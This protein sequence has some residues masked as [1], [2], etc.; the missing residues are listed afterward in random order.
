[1]KKVYY[2]GIDY[3]KNYSTVCILD[4]DRSVVVEATVR[5]NTKEN[6]ATVFSRVGCAISVGF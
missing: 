1:M 5:S 6:F 3:H 4:A 2:A